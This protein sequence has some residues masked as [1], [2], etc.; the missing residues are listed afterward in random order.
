MSWRALKM[1]LLAAPTLLWAAPGF[2]AA[3]DE[4]RTYSILIGSDLPLPGGED[5]W[6]HYVDDDVLSFAQL[7]LALAPGS[8]QR[9]RPHPVNLHLPS[10]LDIVEGLLGRKSM[11]CGSTLHAELWGQGVMVGPACAE[12]IEGSFRGVM[13]QLEDAPGVRNV[14]LIMYSGHGDTP[15]RSDGGGRRAQESFLR[16]QPGT[17]GGDGLLPTR[18]L[19]KWIQD[20]LSDADLVVLVIDACRQ[21]EQEPSLGALD[22][23]VARF[24]INHK[25]RELEI[26]RGPVN[27]VVLSGLLG[28]AD[29]DHNGRITVAELSRF[30]MLNLQY[31][32]PPRRRSA[33]ESTPYLGSVRFGRSG[34]DDVIIA[35]RESMTSSVPGFM[36]VPLTTSQLKESARILL[37]VEDQP[38]KDGEDRPE[39]M[40]GL[41]FAIAELNTRPAFMYD[42]SRRPADPAVTL[43]IPRLDHNIKVTVVQSSVV[44]GAA[45]DRVIESRSYVVTPAAPNQNASTHPV[46]PT[47]ALPRE[48]SGYLQ[49]TENGR[50][51]FTAERLPSWLDQLRGPALHLCLSTGLEQWVNPAR[52]DASRLDEASPVW[53]SVLTGSLYDWPEDK[54]PGSSRAEGF[55]VWT[56]RVTGQYFVSTDLWRSELLNRALLE[57]A[58]VSGRS[59]SADTQVNGLGSFLKTWG[60]QGGAGLRHLNKAHTL[61]LAVSGGVGAYTAAA[62]RDA[63]FMMPTVA[64]VAR[65]TG[66]ELYGRVR[67]AVHPKVPVLGT[68]AGTDLGL[69]ISLTP[70]AHTATILDVKY[71]PAQEDEPRYHLYEHPVIT[72]GIGGEVGVTWRFGR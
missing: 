53:D 1:F 30:F 18:T 72:P 67:I 60:I 51:L 61:S 41:G 14:V 16:I 52:M 5:D 32:A 7:A 33:N 59:L 64:P 22:D 50:T 40:D 26:Q 38:P 57:G 65:A 54:L 12:D 35:Y 9:G 24:F 28:G 37:T 48:L 70:Y 21:N 31:E 56:G 4:I 11:L 47:G 46:A 19:H 71:V 23:K 15:S 55:L 63:W 43:W 44:Q 68:N 49:N 39:G 17:D 3:E 69:F 29:F 20:Y 36:K 27:H 66:L 8:G 2:A 10:N 25:I 58:V 13:A 42:L 34:Y 45:D 62:Y 6:L